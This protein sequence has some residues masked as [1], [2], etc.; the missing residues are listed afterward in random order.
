MLKY[1]ETLV[2]LLN[3]NWHNDKKMVDYCLKSSKYIQIDS[4]FV[5]A[6]NTKPSITK[7]FYY[8]DEYDAPDT[9]YKTF[10]EKNERNAP[11]LHNICDIDCKIR[12]PYFIPQYSNNRAD[13]CLVC[14]TYLEAPTDDVIREVTESELIQLN[15]AIAEV[16]K[17]YTKRLETYFK[18]Y[19]DKI[20]T[21][22]YYANR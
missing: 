15:E 2:N 14:V 7:E 19:S 18:R 12:K 13:N 5:D 21:H 16:R 6:C 1:N 22:G 10:M 3:A 20:S 17:D 8:N 11:Q 4:M 9:G